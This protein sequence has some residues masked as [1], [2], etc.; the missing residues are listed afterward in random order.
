MAADDKKGEEFV[1]YFNISL[2]YNPG[3]TTIPDEKFRSEEIGLLRGVI[4]RAK[5]YLNEEICGKCS[6]SHLCRGCNVKRLR[7]ILEGKQ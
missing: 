6:H 1:N 2:P 7:D 4:T 3:D 5:K